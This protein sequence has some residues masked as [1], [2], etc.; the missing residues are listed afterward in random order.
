[1]AKQRR[2]GLVRNVTTFDR[3]FTDVLPAYQQWQWI[4]DTWK[5]RTQLTPSTALA[6]VNTV[7]NLALAIAIG[8]GITIAW[9][10]KALQGAT[11]TELHKSWAFSTSALELMTAGKSFNL[12]ALAAITAKLALVDNVLLQ[13][14]AGSEP[15]TFSQNITNLTMPIMSTLP[16][17]YT[18]AYNTDGS[19][20]FISD[21]FANDIYRYSTSNNL[22]GFDDTLPNYHT[23][24][25]GVCITT[26]QG[27]GFNISCEPENVGS[28][29]E[30]NKTAA[31]AATFD[32]MSSTGSNLN[33]D[34]ASIFD[35]SS[36]SLP[37]NTELQNNDTTYSFPYDTI[38]LASSYSNIYGNNVARGAPADTCTAQ[39]IN[40]NCFLRPAIINYPVQIT[41]VSTNS[42]AANGIKLVMRSGY[43]FA[44]ANLAGSNGEVENGQ[45]W[46]IE[47]GQPTDDTTNLASIS[48]VMD[49][50]FVGSASLE[51]NESTGYVPNPGQGPLSAWWV[52]WHNTGRPSSSCVMEIPDPT[53]WIV[54]QLNSLMLRT[55]ISAAVSSN[56]PATANLVGMLSVDTLI[57]K[58]HWAFMAAAQAVMF[59]CVVCVLPTYYGFWE[60]GRKVTLGPVEIASAF[61]A[62]ALQHPA[63]AG[64]GE[65]DMLL[66]EMGQRKVRYGEVEGSGKLG[67]DTQDAVKRI[68][69][70]TVPAVFRLGNLRP[71]EEAWRPV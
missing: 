3:Y 70:G 29:F 44:T 27:F 43:S 52:G 50:L 34:Y 21:D 28:S 25:E 40:R 71:R 33:M 22:I 57:Y 68:D 59:L 46:G 30:V 51:Y 45:I 61:Q 54:Q 23:G 4:N 69:A 42:H 32:S 15:G 24:C 17:A 31:A 2:S 39:V 9:W 16:K 36:Y 14:A 56:A 58:S 7:S 41:N 67:V 66:K 18:G 55:S 53:T 38:S 12:I 5:E 35:T 20:G 62:P 48:A 19:T 63:V 26:V 8:N 13:R 65:V 6:I 10:R 47:V 64:G 37:A 1:M 11:V 60:L 49:K